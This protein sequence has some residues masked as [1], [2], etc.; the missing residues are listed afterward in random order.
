M[1]NFSSEP[2]YRVRKECTYLN[3]SFEVNTLGMRGEGQIKK[4]DFRPQANGECLTW[5]RMVRTFKT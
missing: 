3:R 4:L 2:L 5:P 1:N